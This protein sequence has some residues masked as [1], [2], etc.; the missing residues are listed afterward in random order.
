MMQAKPDIESKIKEALESAK[1]I[2]TVDAP[3][4]F[5]DKTV[6]RLRA[7]AAEKQTFSYTGILKIAAVIMLLLV[8]VYTIRYVL[9]S[10]QPEVIAVNNATI[11][12]FVS[13]YQP[14]DANELTFEEKIDK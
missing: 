3:A 7:S 5:T 9:N 12:D 6:N 11:K 4:F 14:S 2:K 1:R 10:R 8:N 13:E